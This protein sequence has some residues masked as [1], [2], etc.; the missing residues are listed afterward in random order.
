ML[1]LLLCRCTIGILFSIIEQ[2]R[3]VLTAVLLIID[4]LSSGPD[5]EPIILQVQ[6]IIAA[7]YTSC[8][9]THKVDRK[10]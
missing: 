1:I 4:P 8:F 5:R 6:R 3:I 10:K 2:H 9:G 7:Y